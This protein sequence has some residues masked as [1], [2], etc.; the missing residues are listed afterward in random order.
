MRTVAPI[1]TVLLNDENP[2]VTKEASNALANLAIRKPKKFAARLSD[3]E[4]AEN[5]LRNVLFSLE[6]N[7]IDLYQRIKDLLVDERNV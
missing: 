5:E 7:D 1:V 2:T 4:L 6:Q 3:M